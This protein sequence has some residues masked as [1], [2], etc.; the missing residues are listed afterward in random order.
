VIQRSGLT[1]ESPWRISCWNTT[2]ITTVATAPTAD[3]RYEVRMR[4]RWLAIHDA[5]TRVSRPSAIWRATVRRS[6]T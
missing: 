3:R 1:R 6:Q 2:T 4:P 5:T